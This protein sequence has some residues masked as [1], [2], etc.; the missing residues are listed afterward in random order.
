ML[1]PPECPQ[2]IACTSPRPAVTL[3]PCLTPLLPSLRAL[4][5]TLG[6]RT[7]EEGM[8]THLL[9]FL[10]QALESPLPE[11]FQWAARSR[12]SSPGEPYLIMFAEQPGGEGFETGNHPH[13]IELRRGA[14][15]LRQQLEANGGRPDFSQ[16]R[17]PQFVAPDSS[18]SNPGSSAEDSERGGLSTRR[19]SQG[20][21]QTPPAGLSQREFEEA[22]AAAAVL[23]RPA[24]I[25]ETPR[26]GQYE[27]EGPLDAADVFRHCMSGN[28]Q[29]VQRF[30]ELG[31][32]ADT[33][34]KSAYG[35]DVGPD[36][37]FTKPSDGTTVLNYV[38][39]W[40]DIIGESNADAPVAIAKLLLTHNADLQ[41][42]DAQDL[43]FTPVHNATA[44][45]AH[46]LVR[47]MLEHMAEA[48]NLTTGDGRAPLHV[49]ALCDDSEDRL[50]TL[51]VLLQRRAG[52]ELQLNFQEPFCGNTPLHVAAKEGH[53]EV[54]G[55]LLEA[56]A[57]IALTNEAGRTPLEE[58]K[59]ELRT[60]NADA[61]P[62]VTRLSKLN[63]TV[64]VMEIAA[65]AFI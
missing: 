60:L 54:V 50:R 27:Q 61:Q 29:Q 40:S 10:V 49:L 23:E 51:E 33:V 19:S 55:R 7:F 53:S 58:A 57:S 24:S 9:W 5:N 32:H 16:L 36:V 39:T 52:V 64:S 47:A 56:G 11:P 28:V 21:N 34:Y 26:N 46:A 44:N 37:A 17:S 1:N 14:D 43:W 48:V 15:G 41:R 20:G 59:E 2:C 31:G 4:S 38:A 65:I 8:E 62:N 12:L 63:E 25:P 45:G 30:L 42:D 18:R 22:L 6:L 3:C 35:W 13:L